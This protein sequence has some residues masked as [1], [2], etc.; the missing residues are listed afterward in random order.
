MDESVGASQHSYVSKEDVDP[1]EKGK[2]IYEEVDNE[3]SGVMSPQDVRQD[4]RYVGS[5]IGR[6]RVG[7]R[8]RDLRNTFTLARD[9]T[10][11]VPQGSRRG[12][13]RIFT[14]GRGPRRNNNRGVP[15]RGHRNGGNDPSD[16]GN[17]RDYGG[18]DSD[19]SHR[20]HG[21]RGNENNNPNPNN[22]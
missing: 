3:V 12:R 22:N 5:P 18:N 10:Y 7:P 17:N 16:R 21:P 19:R 15:F 13:G 2:S 20:N 8:P 11:D 14:R 9:E 1:L 4:P 6:P